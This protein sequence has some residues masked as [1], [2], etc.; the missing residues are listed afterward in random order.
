MNKDRLVKILFSLLTVALWQW[1]A[2]VCVQ[3]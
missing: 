2:T 3:R 1:L